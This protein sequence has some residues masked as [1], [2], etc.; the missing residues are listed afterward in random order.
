[1]NHMNNMLDLYQKFRDGL[2]GLVAL[3]NKHVHFGV[4]LIKGICY[5]SDAVASVRQ[6]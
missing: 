4:H 6:W 2:V 5:G 3:P 1:M